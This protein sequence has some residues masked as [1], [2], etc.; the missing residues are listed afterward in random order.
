MTRNELET[1]LTN[2]GYTRTSYEQDD[3]W[4]KGTKA[5]SRIRIKN[6]DGQYP[7]DTV[8]RDVVSCSGGY[9]WGWSIQKTAHVSKVYIEGGKLIIPRG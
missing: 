1:L 9:S 2:A 8:I 4:E 5:K 3:V 7:T 6:T